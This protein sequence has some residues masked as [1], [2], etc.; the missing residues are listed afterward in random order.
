MVDT[1]AMKYLLE[2]ARLSCV[3]GSTRAAIR[4]YRDF[5]KVARFSLR[6]IDKVGSPDGDEDKEYISSLMNQAK[7]E[8]RE[9]AKEKSRSC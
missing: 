8:V 4:S 2:E 5:F 3:E 6:Y 7:S 9:I 1:K